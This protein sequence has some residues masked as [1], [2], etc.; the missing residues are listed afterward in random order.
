M[1]A[2]QVGP[3]RVPVFRGPSRDSH[4][5]LTEKWNG[6]FHSGRHRESP[7]GLIGP[8]GPP[9][10]PDKARSGVRPP[11]GLGHY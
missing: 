3:E 11:G 10:A 9:T 1:I 4:V 7:L 5:C 8:H 2:A 6:V